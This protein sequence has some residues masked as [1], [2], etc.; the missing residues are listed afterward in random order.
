MGSIHPGALVRIGGIKVKSVAD[1]NIDLARKAAS[2]YNIEN[3]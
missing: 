2:G 3:A 1:L